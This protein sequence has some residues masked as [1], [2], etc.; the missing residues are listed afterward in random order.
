MLTLAAQKVEKK[1]TEK[2]MNEMWGD[3]A[4]KKDQA[5]SN[6]AAWFADAKYAMFIHRGLFSQNANRWQ[7]KTY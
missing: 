3:V 6:N 1:P 5:V 2:P 7:G 4:G